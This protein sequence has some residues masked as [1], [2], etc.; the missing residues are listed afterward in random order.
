[1]L[2]DYICKLSEH[3]YKVVKAVN[4]CISSADF[5]EWMLYSADGELLAIGH[6]NN[7]TIYPG[8]VWDGSTVIGKLYEDAY[9]I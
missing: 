8:F 7:M 3:S 1:M 5:G 2:P 6:T 9:T 4:I